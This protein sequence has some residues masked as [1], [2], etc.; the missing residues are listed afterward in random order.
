MTSKPPKWVVSMDIDHTLVSNCDDPFSER[1]EEAIR[2]L[3]ELEQIVLLNTAKPLWGAL[4]HLDR[5][6]DLRDRLA[7]AAYNGS[8][9]LLPVGE[10]G[11][12]EILAEARIGYD[13]ASKLVGH[14]ADKDIRFM[15][16]TYTVDN[17]GPTGQIS[18][19]IYYTHD[20][21][22]ATEYHAKYEKV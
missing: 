13:T 7:I 3:V 9:N 12:R 5:A 22:L 1:V 11:K 10:N 6:E 20:S 16:Y 4:Y 8:L 17:A 19:V 21:D 18:E 2:Q 14:F 15:L